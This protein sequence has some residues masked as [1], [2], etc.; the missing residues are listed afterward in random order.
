MEQ[1]LTARLRER[2]VA[3]LVQHHQIEPGEVVGDAA[4]PAGSRL[5]LEPVDEVDHGIEPG[6]RPVP[7][8]RPGERDGQL[9]LARAGAAH[10][11]DVALVG[12]E[13]TAAEVAHQTLVDR[14]PDKGELGEV[15]GQG[16]LKSA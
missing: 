12:Q 8:A 4:L 14:R 10:Q 9:R 2:Q 15:L 11:H 7:D 6:P 3:E 16:Q 1:Q 5:G 13:L